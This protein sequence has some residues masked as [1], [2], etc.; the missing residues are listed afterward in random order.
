MRAV[1][2]N[3]WVGQEPEKLR[4]NLVELV[5]DLT[6]E[7][8]GPP[9][10][11]S[12]QEA[13]RYSGTIPG[14][15]RV[16]VDDGHP[17][18]A[19]CV[20]LVRKRGVE[21]THRHV[22]RAEGPRW[23]GPKHGLMHE[24]KV[25]PGVTIVHDGQAWVVLGIHRIP[26]RAMNPEA[27]YAETKAVVD[28]ATTRKPGRPMAMVGDFNGSANDAD[29]IRLANATGTNVTLRGIDGAL[30]RNVRVQS[31]VRISQQYGSDGHRPVVLNFEEDS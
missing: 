12:L 3:V 29:I 26:N 7:R 13:K 14:Y 22:V 21:I 25:F 17:D 20:L 24:P 2:F 31:A 28:W 6:F 4:R 19:G 9:H 18:D 15:E 10:I 16:A 30:H 1:S 8:T 11:L 5:D 27:S 23:R